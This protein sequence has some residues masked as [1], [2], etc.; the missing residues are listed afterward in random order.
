MNRTEDINI[1]SS[2]CMYKRV[3]K[4]TNQFLHRSRRQRK[5]RNVFQF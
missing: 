2:D 4:N 3:L 1:N 5:D